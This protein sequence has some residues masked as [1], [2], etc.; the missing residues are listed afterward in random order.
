[1]KNKLLSVALFCALGANF[2]SGVEIETKNG[3][4]EFGGIDASGFSITQKP[5]LKC[6]PK[7]SGTYESINEN[8]SASIRARS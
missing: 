5:V 6:S 7:I 1:M 4:Y 8:T 3:Y 2:A